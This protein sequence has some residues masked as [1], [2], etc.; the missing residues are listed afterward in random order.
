MPYLLQVVVVGERGITLR[1]GGDS[2]ACDGGLRFR[3]CNN[4]NPLPTFNCLPSG[5]GI[6]SDCSISIAAR[7]QSK[8]LAFSC[9]SFS[10]AGRDEVFMAP[11]PHARPRHCKG[12]SHI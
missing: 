6:V 4:L 2:E 1:G 7:S 10:F 3:I 8:A 5:S 9:R 11:A 12:L